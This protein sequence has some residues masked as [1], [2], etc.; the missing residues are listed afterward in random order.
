MYRHLLPLPVDP[1]RERDAAES[2]SKQSSQQRSAKS[3]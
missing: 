3:A 2:P 1:R